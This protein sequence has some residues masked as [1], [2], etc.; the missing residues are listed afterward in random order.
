MKLFIVI[1]IDMMLEAHPGDEGSTEGDIEKPF[2]RDSKDDKNRGEGKKHY[3]Q[4]MQIMVIG[5]QAV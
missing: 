3:D 2:V 1:F 4:P 5:L